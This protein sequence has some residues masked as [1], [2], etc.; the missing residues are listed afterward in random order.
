[1]IERLYKN[2][3]NEKETANEKMAVECP[4]KWTLHFHE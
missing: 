4:A 3:E 2:G 1:M